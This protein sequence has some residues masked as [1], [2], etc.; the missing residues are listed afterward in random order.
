MYSSAIWT[1]SG[2]EAGFEPEPI[3]SRGIRAIRKAI[4][5]AQTRIRIPPKTGEKGTTL[6]L[7][8]EEE[9]FFEPVAAKVFEREEAL[10]EERGLEVREDFFEEVERAEAD[11]V[12]DFTISIF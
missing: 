11:F 7:D 2:T 4:I 5:I 6:S 3:N 8:W 12:D 10:A 9:V 1:E